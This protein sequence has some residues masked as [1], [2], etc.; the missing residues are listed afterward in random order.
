MAGP[1]SHYFDR[2]PEVPSAERSIT[3]SLAD[4]ELELVTDRGMFSPERI[5]AGTKLLLQES[6]GPSA[7]HDVLD[8]GC[9]YGPI[10]LTLARRAPSTR[11]W[12]VD[13]N[14]R[15][16]DLCRRNAAANGLDNV[17]AVLVDEH[18]TPLDGTALPDHF[19]ALWSNP[20]I[21]IGKQALHAMLEH[22]LSALA[23]GGRAWLVVQKHL[24]ADSLARWLDERGWTTDRRTSRAG[25]RI[26]EVSAR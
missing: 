8:L 11:V 15:A 23:E 3:L 4:V 9:G 12:A 21:R 1:S 7:M 24:G 13:V 18:G 17:T 2:S 22:W 14:E 6:P 5:D 16:V 25:Y 19:D 10:A 20:S 26:L